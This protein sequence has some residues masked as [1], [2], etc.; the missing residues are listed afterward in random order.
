MWAELSASARQMRDALQPL[1]LERLA[2]LPVLLAFAVGGAL[3]AALA[4][5]GAVRD[6]AGR[7]APDFLWGGSLGAAAGVLSAALLVWRFAPDLLH[8]ALLRSRVR[9]DRA[10][11]RAERALEAP[12]SPTPGAPH[13]FS[14]WARARMLIAL[15]TR[16]AWLLVVALPLAWAA[17]V[18]A[19]LVGLIER[20]V[21]A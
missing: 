9:H 21:P 14:R 3:L 20:A 13:R 7:L 1:D 2:C 19:D 10:K 15:H 5:E 12:T 11:A 16:G 4:V 17:L 8:G 6:L 18:A